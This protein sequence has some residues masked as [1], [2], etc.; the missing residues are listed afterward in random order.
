MRTGWSAFRLAASFRSS[1]L[2]VEQWAP[3]QEVAVTLRTLSIVLVRFRLTL[4]TLLLVVSTSPAQTPAVP[5][6]RLER[7]ASVDAA[8]ND[9]SPIGFVAVG[10]TGNIAIGQPQDHLVRFFSPRGTPTTVLGRKGQGPG[11]FLEMRLHGWMVDTLWIADMDTRRLTMISPDPAV[12]R[13]ELWPQ[14]VR[15]RAGTAGPLPS[16]IFA[17]PWAL[18][19]DGTVLVF[20]TLASG[21]VPGWMHRPPRG[22]YPFLRIRLD[23]TYERVV[24][25]IW[26]PN[27][28]CRVE[29]GTRVFA[30]PQCFEPFWATSRAGGIVVVGNIDRSDNSMDYVRTTAVNANGDTLFTRLLPMPRVRIPRA[31]ADSIRDGL[32]RALARSAP[33]GAPAVSVEVSETYPP[34]SQ[35]LIAR[36][37]QSVW[38]EGGVATGDR[39]WH[40]LDVAG[41]PVGTVRVPR[42]TELRVVTRERVWAVERDRDGLESVVIYRVRR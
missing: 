14:G 4:V 3:V 15:F 28:E 21:P 36:D 7:E 41:R 10:A 22:S 30:K 13:S 24:A 33:R 9:L 19:P 27:A 25:W 35:A 6:L 5:L 34:V 20:A 32:V 12:A 23:G 8:A 18:Y 29:S 39:V 40:I 26:E 11:E 31:V 1:H 17:V 2:V 37:E 38:L 42:G 16:F